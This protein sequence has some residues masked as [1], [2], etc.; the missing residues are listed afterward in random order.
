[1]IEREYFKNMVPGNN[2]LGCCIEV[3]E[4]HFEDI[5][6]DI[7]NNFSSFKHNRDIFDIIFYYDN[8]NGNLIGYVKEYRI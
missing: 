7:N 1:M 8:D 2:S 3:S 5:I 4:K 6:I